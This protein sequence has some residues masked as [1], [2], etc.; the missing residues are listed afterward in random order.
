MHAS[1]DSAN[2]RKD[3]GQKSPIM[4]SKKT[5]CTLALATVLNQNA[6]APSYLRIL[7]ACGEN[8]G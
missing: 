5:I 4:V 7:L 6:Q 8:G 1:W 3:L 2:A